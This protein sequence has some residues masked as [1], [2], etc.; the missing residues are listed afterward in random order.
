MKP[1][2]CVYGCEEL[3]GLAAEEK[4]LIQALKETGFLIEER[5]W[6]S[7]ACVDCEIHLLRNTWDYCTRFQ[8][9]LTFLDQL[10]N[11]GGLILNPVELLR[12]NLNKRYLVHLAARGVPVVETLFFE[13]SLPD[14]LPSFLDRTETVVIKPSVSANSFRTQ[15]SSW[16][17]LKLKSSDYWKL[18]NGAHWMLQPYCESVEQEGE[19]S[20]IYF[21]GKPSHA[22]RKVP[23]AGDF[24]VQDTYGG[25][26]VEV[27]FS[28]SFLSIGGKVHA[29]LDWQPAYSRVDLV[30]RKGNWLLMELELVEPSLFF[31]LDEESARRFVREIA[32]RYSV[33]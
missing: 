24:R 1:R 31:E 3:S 25:K 29:A 12:W 6:E 33:V 4:P 32:V 18:D 16:D 28:E 27:P 7:G 30:L 20:L 23:V 21:G 14:K 2:I 9:F 19:M 5:A 13:S 22:V 26:A 10:Q 11:S 8:E 15:R 17:E